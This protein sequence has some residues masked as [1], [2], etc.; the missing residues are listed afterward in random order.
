[1]VKRP[2]GVAV[3]GIL[4]AM[5]SLALLVL[6]LCCAVA[7]TL[8]KNGVNAPG[9]AP[10]PAMPPWIAGFD[11]V[12]CALLVG[13][14]AWGIATMAGL[15]GMRGWARVSV[16]IFG[17][18]MALLGLLAMGTSVLM[19]VAFPMPALADV[20]PAQ[21]QL[22]KSMFRVVFLLSAIVY[23]LVGTLGITWL[24][25]FNRR[26]V[27]AAFAG[28]EAEAL[29]ESP[30]RRPLL[31]GAIAV[32]SLTG[33]P[34]CALMAWSPFP[35]VLFGF[36]FHGA[37]KVVF[38][39]A[40]GLAQG[41]AGAA[42][43]QL[44]EWGRR[45][46]IGLLGLGAVN[47]AVYLVRPTLLMRANAEVSRAMLVQQPLWTEHFQTVLYR[48]TFGMSIVLIAAVMVV[49]VAYRSR[50]RPEEEPQ[51]RGPMLVV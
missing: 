29:V 12:L 26:R 3:H 47:C 15:F 36:S 37:A 43:W 44:K 25:Y 10:A 32:L 5:V 28:V 49:L 7:G 31:V 35:A 8:G 1:M 6:A 41:V 20:D 46:E 13:L 45:L 27:R 33:A 2:V 17:G 23:G 9:A 39:V 22:A 16:L 40:F 42:L 18:G 11:L 24:V 38:Y 14:A 30:S 48:G 50:F 4:L 19:M 51:P 34:L 21:A